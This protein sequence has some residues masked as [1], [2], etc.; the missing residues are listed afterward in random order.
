MT[1]VS[2][3]TIRYHKV[4]VKEETIFPPLDQDF[5][6]FWLLRSLGNEIASRLVSFVWLP[7]ST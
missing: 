6:R 7:A 5:E 2:Q 3:G 1:D 4:A